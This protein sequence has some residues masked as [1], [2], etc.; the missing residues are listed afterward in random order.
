MAAVERFSKPAFA[1]AMDASFDYIR[2]NYQWLLMQS[3]GATSAMADW[4]PTKWRAML[5]VPG[6]TTTV[7]TATNNYSE[8]DAIVLT[9]GTRRFT[10]NLTWAYGTA[11]WLVTVIEMC[12]HDGVIGEQCQD[13]ITLEYDDED[14]FIGTG[15]PGTDA[16]HF[17]FVV[18]TD[19]ASF[20]MPTPQFLYDLVTPAIYDYWVDWGTGEPVEHITSW[21]QAEATHAYFGYT[22]SFTVK[23]AGRMD[24]WRW[25]Y[26]QPST[27]HL[28]VTDFL[29]WGDVHI[30]EFVYMFTGLL[31]MNY[32]ATD[33]P[34]L[35][36][37]APTA[38]SLY[39]MFEDTA[40]L[41]GGDF[42]GWDVSTITEFA[43]MFY[44][45][46]IDPEGIGAWDVSVGTDFS[47]MFSGATAFNQDISAW[48][49]TESLYFDTM[50]YGASAWT[51]AN[52]DA[53]L[54]AWSLLLFTNSALNFE[55]DAQYTAAAA[56]LV[57]TSAPNS[58]T[59]I[60]NGPA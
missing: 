57:L 36:T 59:I 32:S 35:D 11:K 20:R 29:Q 43:Y 22:G 18:T 9:R 40:A 24:C 12:Y 47:S 23:V 37:G 2:D 30:Q 21:N 7:E 52:Y 15:F 54:E 49:P 39:S 33:A 38:W 60:D 50:L 27:D 14:N 53:L 42:S 5:V 28:K 44:N 25:Y 17:K 1:D 4:G 16:Q 48:Q 56:R 3:I 19:N 58:W 46:G 13:G 45:S 34:I 51:N 31:A 10:F 26:N 8:P 55:C 6:W 41:T